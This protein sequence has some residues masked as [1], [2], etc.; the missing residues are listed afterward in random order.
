MR[1]GIGRYSSNVAKKRRNGKTAKIRSYASCAACPRQLSSR[2][3]CTMWDSRQARGQLEAVVTLLVVGFVLWSVGQRGSLPTAE[4][5]T[6][7]VC[8]YQYP[9]QTSHRWR[10]SHQRLTSNPLIAVILDSHVSHIGCPACQ[11]PVPYHGCRKAPP[12]RAEI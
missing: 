4:I 3:S 9:S 5:G 12:F 6:G 8:L 1:L 2:T 7:A 10:S 11:G